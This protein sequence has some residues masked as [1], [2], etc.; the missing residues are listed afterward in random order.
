M[1]FYDAYLGFLILTKLVFI[2]YIVQNRFAPSDV[3]KTR[4]DQLDNVFK[5]GTSILMIYLFRPRNQQPIK[6]DNHTKLCLFTF[7]IL[8]IFDFFKEKKEEKKEAAKE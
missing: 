2:Y 6:I 7:G 3:A 4:I 1:N 5:I 8:T